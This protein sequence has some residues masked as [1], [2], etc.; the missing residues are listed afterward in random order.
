MDPSDSAAKDPIADMYNTFFSEFRA[1]VD[2]SRDKA[3]ALPAE[4]QAAILDEIKSIA[5]RDGLTGIDVT[6]DK[7]VAIGNL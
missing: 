1:T 3:V 4:V 6:P 2:S 5:R 7:T